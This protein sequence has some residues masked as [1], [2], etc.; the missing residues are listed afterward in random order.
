MFTDV[1]ETVEAEVSGKHLKKNLQILNFSTVSYDAFLY[2]KVTTNPCVK[3]G[4]ITPSSSRWVH[5]GESAGSVR[6]L[7][8]ETLGTVNLGKKLETLED[9]S[10]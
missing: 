9:P 6:R 8:W 4:V 2:S 7:R 5:L 3:I 1:G 10:R